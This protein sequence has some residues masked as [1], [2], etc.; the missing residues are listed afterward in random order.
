MTDD[1]K[2]KAAMERMFEEQKQRKEMM[3]SLAENQ[4]NHITFDKDDEEVDDEVD[5][6]DVTEE[7]PLEGD[8]WMFD[9]D[10][11]E[12]VTIKINPVLEGEEG[13]KRLELQSKFKGDERFKLGE[14]FI[15]EDENKVEQDLRD[16]I[17]KELSAEKDQALDVLR[18][19]FGDDKVDNKPKVQSNTWSSAARFDPDAEDA[20]K[21][22][23]HEEEEKEE[24][25]DDDDDFFSQ[26]KTTNQSAIPTVSTDK[27]FE[28]NTNLKPLFGGADDKPFTLFGDSSTVEKPK[29]LFSKEEDDFSS[30]TPKQQEG[31]I[32][33]GVMFFFHFEDPSLMKK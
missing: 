25:D 18:S 7:K 19:M 23:A 20:T 30:F 26:Q 29:P 28:V 11:D 8:K 15:D 27:H 3:K 1:E 13:R 24:A 22:L 12:E 17:S 10:S 14:D 6:M 5:D 2:R 9:S 31:R 21:Y 16:D 32:G 4:Q 33:L